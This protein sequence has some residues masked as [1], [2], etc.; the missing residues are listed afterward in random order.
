MTFFFKTLTV[1]D[2]IGKILFLICC[3]I[4]LN[5]C[6]QS[7]KRRVLVVHSYEESYVAY[8]D[9]NEMIKKQF[10]KEGVSTDI[11]TFYLDCETYNEK[12]E[13]CRMRLLLDSL[14]RGWTPE[15]ILVNEDQATYSLL[16]CGHPLVKKTPVVF[17]GVNYPNQKLLDEHPLVTGHHDKI[18]YWENIKVAKQ[19]LGENV[20]LFTL[21]DS[22]YLDMKIRKDAREQF[23]NHKITGSFGA[24]ELPWSE[25]E[26][27]CRKE[28][29]TRFRILGMRTNDKL[30]GL[31]LIWMLST[32][33]KNQCYLQL[34]RDFTTVS[35]TGLCKNPCMTVINEAF[36]YNEGLLGGYMTTLPI[37]AEEEVATATRILKG[38]S[39]RNIPI[40]ESRKEYVVDWNVMLQLGMQKKQ[41]PQNYHI[42]NIP[43]SKKHP[44]LWFAGVAVLGVGGLWGVVALLWLYFRE[45]KRKKK[46]LIALKNEK[47]ML[48]LAIEGGTTYVW[49]MINNEFIFED[50]FWRTQGVNPHKVSLEELVSCIHPDHSEDVYNWK[51]VEPSQ[52][53]KVRLRCKFYK[54]EYQW[55]EFRYT[56]YLQ[57]GTEFKTAG[58]MLNIQDIKEHEEELEAARLLAE[59][60]ELKQSFLANMSHE[61]R[62]PLNSIVGFSNILAV[63]EEL[64]LE[65]KQEYIDTINKN[66]DLLLKLIND[67]LEL[68]RIESGYMSF[69]Y[70]KYMVKD[71]IDDVY[72]THQ[73]LI[74]PR[75]KF[76]KEEDGKC[77]EFDVDRDRLI[78]VLTN[79]LNNATKFTEKGYIK[80]GYY[81]V[82]KENTVHIYV[83]DTGKGISNE[84]LQIVFS[85]FYKQN[86]FSQGVGL[87]LSICKVIVEKLGG[88]ITLQSEVDK[89][90]RFTVILP[91]RVVS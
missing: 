37:Q 69:C 44:V 88:K 72:M 46:A 78:Q 63:D 79:F 33:G 14:T 22:T 91:C 35:I 61:I 38:E 8:P 17:A 87:G 9:F 7:K 82:P 10:T 86:E 80:I 36:G 83:E 58:L 24:V 20:Y 30:S 47:E 2:S 49:R 23:K 3:F 53:K 90:S 51:N 60:A 43:L 64:S 73:V 15:V 48:A 27:L 12:E 75:L 68:S 18:N 84:E 19:L 13:L 34:K 6:S 29:Y 66:N 77:L 85:R 65:E 76:L 25:Q 57:E 62:T 59:K 54:N 81:Y 16:K 5:A 21:L 50:A 28:G 45:Q 74:T 40:V 32:Y 56:T 41:I 71:L 42:I 39:P 26:R 1:I 70:K 11:R 89:G 55:W 67:I 52:K 4:L 31:D